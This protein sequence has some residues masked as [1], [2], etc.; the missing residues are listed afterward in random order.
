LRHGCG[1]SPCKPCVD[2]VEKE[3]GR[4]GDKTVLP[5]R[6]RSMEIRESK[7]NRDPGFHRKRYRSESTNTH[8][9]IN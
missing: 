5:G 8:T 6:I 2:V 1:S 3:W 4:T 9:Y 7:I